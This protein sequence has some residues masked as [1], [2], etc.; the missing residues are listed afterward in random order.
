M[1]TLT[2]LISSAVGQ[3]KPASPKAHPQEVMQLP[4]PVREGGMPLLQALAERKS[5]RSFSAEPLSAQVLSNV[6]WAGFG[7]NRN[8]TGGRTAPSALNGQEVDVYVS[9]ASGVY[10]YAYERHELTLVAA[11]DARRVTGFQDFV[12]R[13]PLDLVYV[14]DLSE[15]AA[16]PHQ[17]RMLFAAASAG[18][19][20]ENVYLYAASAGLTTVVRAWFDRDALGAA[21]RLG[22][23]EHVLLAQ[24]VGYP[25]V[26]SS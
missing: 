12:D 13:A 9:L 16:V 11:V 1:S 20:A 4:P 25:A 21:L 26:E 5:G 22:S 23:H 7:I 18:A 10:V 24:T 15:V 6:L 2:K 17:Q 19:I 8:Q 14:A 3:L